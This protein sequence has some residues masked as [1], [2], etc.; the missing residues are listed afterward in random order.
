M[1]LYG[2]FCIW[3]LTIFLSWNGSLAAGKTDD[4]RKNKSLSKL[5]VGDIMQCTCNITYSG[6]G[7]NQRSIC[8]IK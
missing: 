6:S 5:D 1:D 8:M 7:T 4:N 3:S 2:L